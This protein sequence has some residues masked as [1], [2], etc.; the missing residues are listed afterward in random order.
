MDDYPRPSHQED[1]DAGWIPIDEPY[2]GTG[3]M[4]VGES[5]DSINCKCAEQFWFG[6]Q[7]PED[8]S[9]PGDEETGNEEE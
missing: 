1:E 5:E 7:Q 8:D 2:P 3:E 6:E 4:V 9:E